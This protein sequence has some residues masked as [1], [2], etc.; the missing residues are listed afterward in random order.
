MTI[1]G[2]IYK[3]ASAK[4]LGISNQNYADRKDTLDKF[5]SQWDGQDFE[6]SYLKWITKNQDHRRLSANHKKPRGLGDTIAKVTKKVGIKPCG[7]CKQRQQWL[8]EKIPY[9][10]KVTS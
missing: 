9:K 1:A 6:A 5:L 8:N 3:G 4:E 7:G 10:T 2:E